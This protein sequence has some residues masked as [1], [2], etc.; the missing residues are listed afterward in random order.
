MPIKSV[1]WCGSLSRLLAGMPNKYRTPA[2]RHST[3]TVRTPL[4]ATPFLAARRR[5]QAAA[6]AALLSSLA[7]AGSAGAASVFYVRGGGD[8]HGIGMSQYG[9]YGYALHGRSYQFILAHYYSGTS[10]GK[11]DPRRTVRVLL[12]T[13]G[14]PVAF[15]GANAAPGFPKPLNPS[16]TYTVKAMP[17]G[18]LSLVEDKGKEVARFTSL[19]VKGAGP[20]SVA[21]LGLYRGALR[22]MPDGHGG[23][24]T[25]DWIGLD[26]YVRGVISAEM[27][28]SWS[29]E[30]LKVQAVAARTYAITTNVGGTAFDLYPDTRSQMY[31]GVAAETAATDAAVAATRGQVVTY[32]GVPVVTYFFNSSGGHTENIENAWR[33][34][35]PKPWLLGVPD[36]YDTAGGDP[37]HRW[38]S[39]MSLAQAAAKLGG[40]VKGQFVGIRVTKHGV[41]PRILTAE[42]VGSGGSTT[43]TGTAL[44]HA[45]GLLTTSAWF[46]TISGGVGPGSRLPGARNDVPAGAKAVAALVPLVQALVAAA[47]PIISGSVLPGSAREPI[48]VQ[49]HGRGGWRTVRHAR[50]GAGGNY[51]VHVPGRGTYRVL[52]RGFAGPAVATG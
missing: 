40:L 42:V 41:S 28:S 8:G 21:G 14:G 7:F 16:V 10:L 17:D 33:G 51:S 19:T 9:A 38:G 32:G 52:F 37:Y 25:V 13:G 15:S 45:F 44:Q 31:T 39:R 30:A 50:L 26:D 34:S 24:Q 23:I 43:V 22:F 29:P 49:V 6:L 11:V 4:I 18:S 5:F 20:V 2:F 1:Y 12:A 27:P 36:P 46:E 35:Q 48:V 47:N 3:N